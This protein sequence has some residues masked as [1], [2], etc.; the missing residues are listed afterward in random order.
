MLRQHASQQVEVVRQAVEIDQRRGVGTVLLSG[1]QR[2]TLRPAADRPADVA[3]RH[4]G[5]AARDG[6][7]RDGRHEGLHGVDAVLEP[8]DRRRSE[9]SHLALAPL[10]HGQQ[11]RDGHQPRGDLRNVVDVGGQPLLVAHVV[12]QQRR[13]GHQFI[14]RAVGLDPFVTLEDPFAADER[15][16]SLVSRLV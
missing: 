14:D 1:T 7:L 16:G 2:R 9:R 11:R 6:E 8:L 12:T 15:R 4:D 13:E 3:H 5:I 10:A